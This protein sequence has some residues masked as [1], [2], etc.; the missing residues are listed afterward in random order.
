MDISGSIGGYIRQEVP[1][2]APDTIAR[3]R[4]RDLQR[5]DQAAENIA[6]I[7]EMAASLNPML[8]NTDI[9]T[10]PTVRGELVPIGDSSWYW[11][12]NEPV[13]PRD[14]DRWPNSPYCSNRLPVDP[15]DVREISVGVEVSLNPCETCIEV[16]PSLFGISGP[17]TV[18]CKR[19]PDPECQ[20]KAPD[21]TTEEDREI[22]PEEL[23]LS[24]QAPPGKIRLM[25][26]VTIFWDDTSLGPPTSSAP[27]QVRSLH[28]GFFAQVDSNGEYVGALDSQI[29]EA[30]SASQ[31]RFDRLYG[32][33]RGNDWIYELGSWYFHISQRARV[34]PESDSPSPY[35]NVSYI[36]WIDVG[37]QANT[38][39]YSELIRRYQDILISLLSNYEDSSY[40][41]PV[42]SIERLTRSGLNWEPRFHAISINCQG[43]PPP[44]NQPMP[45][46]G[47]EDMG[48][49]DETLELLEAI[50]SRLGVEEFP[51][52]APA[53]LVQEGEEEEPLENHAQLWAWT[54]KNLD[55]V[56]GQFPIKIRI[57]DTDPTTE[58]NQEIE[59]SLPNVAEALAEMFG[60]AYQSEIQTDLITDILL[61]LVPEVLATKNAALTG[62]SYSKANASFL[63]YPANAK[64]V[65]VD[66]NFDLERLNSLPEFLSDCRKRIVVY[67]DESRESVLDVLSK[68]EFAAGIIKAAFYTKPSEKDRLLSAIETMIGD[69]A[70]SIPNKE[71]WRD[72]LQRMNRD[73]GK[74]NKDQPLQPEIIEE[75][76]EGL[77]NL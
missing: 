76:H 23:Q 35:N 18:V 58:G 63:G 12:G 64:E 47:D 40:L 30:W 54:A 72:W 16:Q 50:Y 45:T 19:S 52:K 56:M 42:D 26:A 41:S 14:C 60:L 21:P 24:P 74:H 43:W 22:S 29:P 70:L 55:A 65:P 28:S 46:P 62:Q 53:L 7:V 44:S 10:D 57:Q 4:L 20:T 25:Y 6:N 51:V 33:W 39:G 61:R 13:D 48:C 38:K 67:Q 66:Y 32:V 36:F 37:C 15:L 11:S 5:A 8:P 75:P 68:L 31:S 34:I 2:L 71:K 59:L 77:D 73:S 1:D 9:S 69:E 27:G 3:R 49:C 17:P